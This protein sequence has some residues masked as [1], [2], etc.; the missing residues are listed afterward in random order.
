[1]AQQLILSIPAPILT[2]D[3]YAELQGI[4]VKD[5]VNAIQRGR[6]PVYMPP[7]DGVENPARVK[8]YINMVA[9]YADAAKQAGME[10]N[11]QG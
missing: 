2:Y 5:V 6:L 3:A 11:L 8:K 4:G 9:L 7:T 10:F 1:M